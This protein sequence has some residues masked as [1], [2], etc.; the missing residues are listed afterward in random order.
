MQ[1][2]KEKKEMNSKLTEIRDLCMEAR[3]FLD[4]C[5]SCVHFKKDGDVCETCVCAVDKPDECGD[6]KH[7]SNE[8]DGMCTMIV[9]DKGYPR[10]AS[11]GTICS[12][13]ELKK[14]LLSKTFKAIAELV[15]SED[16]DEPTIPDN[17][18]SMNDT[19]FWKTPKVLD[20]ES[21][22]DVIIGFGIKTYRFTEHGI[23][24]TPDGSPVPE[25]VID[26]YRRWKEQQLVPT[27]S[28]LEV[29]EYELKFDEESSTDMTWFIKYGSQ[30]TYHTETGHWYLEGS[31]IHLVDVPRPVFELVDMKIAKDEPKATID[32]EL[33]TNSAMVVNYKNVVYMWYSQSNHWWRDHAVIDAG[34]VPKAVMLIYG[35]YLEE[36][37]NN[38]KVVSDETESDERNW[39]SVFTYNG[40][41][42]TYNT[43][44]DAWCKG[45][46]IIKTND[47]PEEV[48]LALAEKM[49]TEADSMITEVETDCRRQRLITAT[50]NSEWVMFDEKESNDNNWI[51]IYGG[52]E[53]IYILSDDEWRNLDGEFIPTD[54]VPEDVIKVSAIRKVEQQ[55]ESTEK[56]QEAMLIRFNER[57]NPMIEFDGVVYECAYDG[58]YPGEIL[59]PKQGKRFQNHTV[60]QEVKDRYQ[61]YVESLNMALADKT[62]EETTP[63]QQKG[64]ELKEDNGN[65]WTFIFGDS[66]D[67]YAINLTEK[68]WYLNGHTTE[69]G[70]VPELVFMKAIEYKDKQE[71]IYNKK[72]S[73]IT[74]DVWDYCGERYWKSKTGGWFKG[75]LA[76]RFS[77]AVPV[78]SRLLPEKVLKA[79]KKLEEQRRKQ[80]VIKKIDSEDRDVEVKGANCDIVILDDLE[81]KPTEEARL[82]TTLSTK[83]K[84]VWEFDGNL[85]RRDLDDDELWFISNIGYI[86]DMKLFIGTLPPEVR[87]AS[88]EWDLKMGTIPILDEKRSTEKFRVWLFAGEKYIW[89]GYDNLWRDGDLYTISDGDMPFAVISHNQA[90]CCTPIV[91]TSKQIPD[92]DDEYE[93]Y[94]CKDSG[95]TYRWNKQDN[96]WEMLVNKCTVSV[97]ANT[98]P[99]DVKRQHIS[100]LSLNVKYKTAKVTGMAG[101]NIIITCGDKSYE[102]LDNHHYVDRKTDELQSLADVP[103]DVIN[104][105]IEWK[106][107]KNSFDNE[108]NK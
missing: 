99:S 89:D 87:K 38:A 100:N 5:I 24:E 94:I 15:D 103:S 51:F 62:L 47:V 30:Y 16:D 41:E 85:Y 43:I 45:G 53:Y 84:Q 31:Q 33:S 12:S 77:S 32:K 19:V 71:P 48:R 56:A 106:N 14:S 69:V 36:F 54:N 74:V 34:D 37:S 28:E 82:Y 39:V 57:N 2:S 72:L 91:V 11:N 8:I 44:I 7:L 22:K 23:I 76:P 35:E 17:P 55:K 26:C 50:E 42:Y 97:I 70:N 86:S 40:V 29:V 58:F 65:S 80:I 75:Q 88:K 13:H 18:I 81:E 61:V 93:T 96:Y 90:Y 104:C 64:V 73:R 63:K 3:M 79:S 105:N 68:Q 46:Y 52:D 59:S 9:A 49:I 21:G 83:D 60:P 6:C 66:D 67:E 27:P 78:G 107:I 1:Q 92:L 25:P 4:R 95:K 108:Y 102:C 20:V 10:I 98:I 101:D